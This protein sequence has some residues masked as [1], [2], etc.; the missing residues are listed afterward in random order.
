MCDLCTSCMS[1][2]SS[3]SS[4]EFFAL[5]WCEHIN[6]SCKNLCSCTSPIKL[7]TNIVCIVIFTN[8]GSSLLHQVWD[9]FILVELFLY[10]L[11]TLAWTSRRFFGF[12][13]G[14]AFHRWRMKVLNGSGTCESIRL[15]QPLMEVDQESNRTVGY[16]CK[17]QRVC[18]SC[19]TFI[20]YRA[21]TRIKVEIDYFHQHSCNNL[22]LELIS[23]ILKE[24]CKNFIY[25]EKSSLFHVIK[26]TI[27]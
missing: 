15:R 12:A 4:V 23:I 21:S 11:D 10:I 9:L 8:T 18:Q 25:S 13:N 16:S 14:R 17:S 6:L 20:S 3:L 2:W 27:L 26:S 7:F 1:A 24:C 5:A 19:S 22:Y